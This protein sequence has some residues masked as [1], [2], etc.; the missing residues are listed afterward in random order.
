MKNKKNFEEYVKQEMEKVVKKYQHDH[1]LFQP[2]TIT[3]Y[4]IDK[5][6]EIAAFVLFEHIDTDRCS[7]YGTGWL[8]DQYRYSVWYIKGFTEPKQIYS[9][10]DWYRPTPSAMTGSKGRNPVIGLEEVL[11]DGVIATI[12]PKGTQEAYGGLSQV[13]IKITLEG[14]IKEPEDFF[15]QAKNL[16]KRI[17]EKLGYDYMSNAKKL[18][19]KDVAV[20]V[21]ST[22][23]GRD[24][25]FDTVYLVWKDKSGNLKYGVLKDSKRNKEF[26]SIY[27]LKETKKSIIININNSEYKIDKKDLGI[28]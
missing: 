8:G 17:G 10:H 16:V 6:K 18:E 4:I 12:T 13:K 2:T 28:D 1:P 24:Y 3:K 26:L 11:E 5:E 9:D 22:E 7:P 27:H 20:I 15:D 25:G 19:G 23:N 21:W 14:K